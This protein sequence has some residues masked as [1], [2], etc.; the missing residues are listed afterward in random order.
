MPPRCIK[1]SHE[2]IIQHQPDQNKKRR[3]TC[4]QIKDYLNARKKKAKR[5]PNNKVLNQ[6][7]KTLKIFPWFFKM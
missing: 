4:E 1:K 3:Q 7:M 5:H 2:I 6:K